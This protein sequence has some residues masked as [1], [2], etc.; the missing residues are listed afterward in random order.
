MSKKFWFTPIISAAAA[1]VADSGIV[2]YLKHPITL[3]DIKI[4]IL[5]VVFKLFAKYKFENDLKFKI[6][7]AKEHSVN[8]G[9]FNNVEQ[10]E[11]VEISSPQGICEEALNA[12]GKEFAINVKDI[13]KKGL[14]KVRSS[15]KDTLKD[16][17]SKAHSVIDN[18]IAL[19]IKN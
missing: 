17:L 7:K 14:N 3:N 19:T 16:K 12:G 2:V 4:K 13:A 15:Y 9:I 18:G 5:E 10:L 11:S 1:V 6:L 8:V